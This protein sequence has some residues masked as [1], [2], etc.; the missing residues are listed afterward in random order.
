M[1][2]KITGA[3]KNWTIMVLLNKKKNQKKLF[4]SFAIKNVKKDSPQFDNPRIKFIC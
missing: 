1:G 2:L 4:V 3:M